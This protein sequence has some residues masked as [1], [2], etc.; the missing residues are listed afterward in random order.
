MG[1]LSVTLVKRPRRAYQSG[2]ELSEAASEAK[3]L[4]EKATRKPPKRVGSPGVLSETR[5]VRLSTAG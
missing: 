4:A 2:D 1:G 3:K 5:H